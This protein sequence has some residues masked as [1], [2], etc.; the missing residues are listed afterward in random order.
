MR[1]CHRAHLSL[2][3]SHE[4]LDQVTAAMVGSRRWIRHL[5]CSGW[6]WELYNNRARLLYPEDVLVSFVLPPWTLHFV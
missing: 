4:E 3:G 2:R 5:L 6:N 1:A